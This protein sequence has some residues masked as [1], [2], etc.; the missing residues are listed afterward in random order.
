MNMQFCDVCEKPLPGRGLNDSHVCAGC[1]ANGKRRTIE[2]AEADRV[3]VWP[4]ICPS[5]FREIDRDR[6]PD[7]GLLDRVLAWQFGAQGL[8]VFGRTG[9]GKTRCIWQ[10]LRREYLA[11]RDVLALDGFE[12]SKFPRMLMADG[13]EADEFLDAAA[14][15]PIL[16][17]DDPFKCV[18]SPRIEEAIFSIV[19][20]RTA[21]GKPIVLTTNDTG[22]TLQQRVSVER[23]AALVRRLRD[24]SQ[25]V[26]A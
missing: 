3:S 24:Y 16:F 23:G 22:E 21:W 25:Q 6:L 9:R 5:A 7:P 2:R 4:S 17:L 11:G 1:V 19:D 8:S 13:G 15:A 12:L 26:V 10:V 14:E 20:R 18:F